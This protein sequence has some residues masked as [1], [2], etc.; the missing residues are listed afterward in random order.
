[1]PSGFLV[2]ENERVYVGDMSGLNRRIT[3]V[4]SP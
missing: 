4:P 1:M 2:G 3:L